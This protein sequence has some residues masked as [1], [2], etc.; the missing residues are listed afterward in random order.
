MDS[1]DLG[2]LQTALAMLKHQEFA[3]SIK[4]RKILLQESSFSVL[5][6]WSVP[7]WVVSL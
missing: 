6:Q 3:L 2:G 5:E 1:V 4:Y 7:K